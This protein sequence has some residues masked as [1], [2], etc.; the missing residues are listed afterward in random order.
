MVIT[1]T[2]I[3]VDVKKVEIHSSE[4]KRTMISVAERQIK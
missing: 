2:M 1:T 4:S 3:R